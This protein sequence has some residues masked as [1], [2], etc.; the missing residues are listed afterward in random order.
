MNYFFLQFLFNNLL[1]EFN[2]NYNTNLNI[3]L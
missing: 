1:Y 3:F 2:K